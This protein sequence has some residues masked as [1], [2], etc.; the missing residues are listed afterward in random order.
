M[1]AVN[2]A[3]AGEWQQAAPL[4]DP[5]WHHAAG[6]SPDG[7]VFAFG[8]RL[9]LGSKRKYDHGNRENAIDV[10]DPKEKTW[11]RGP[12]IVP[13]R[14]RVVRHYARK[15]VVPGTRNLKSIPAEKASVVS[16]DR[17]QF[18]LP[19]GGSD[20]LGRAHYFTP[21]G[22]VYYDPTTGEWDQSL[23]PIVHS[24]S[25]WNERWLEGGTAPAWNRSAGA[26]ATAPDG[27]MYLVGGQGK[28]K[29]GE[30]KQK[31]RVLGTVEIYDPS[32]EQW[33][34]GSPMNVARQQF[35]AAFGPDGK[36]YVFG[37]CACRGSTTYTVGDKASQER[38]RVEGEAMEH[39]VTRTEVYDPTKDTWSDR[40]AIPTP[41]MSLSAA[42]GLD[43]KI[44]VI[45]GQQRW[46]GEPMSLVEVYDPASDSWSKGPS[47]RIGRQ[48]HASAVTL[49]GK[50]W[51]IGGAGADREIGD[52][53]RLV[54][55]EVGGPQKTVETLQTAPAKK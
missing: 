39:P 24:K 13:L 22:S 43:G 52:I 36:L 1:L 45:G 30:G 53:G 4:P 2:A 40:A 29:Y 42:T 6:A 3:R 34:E 41:R 11:T 23:G 33:S 54:R 10:Y 44:Y 18:E 31:S 9:L 46:G 32:T 27:K 35:G 26:T 20:R 7:H 14:R 15:V 12:E 16:S 38:A 51:V 8:G 21:S 19:F 28:R 37:G 49:D 47:L 55:G 17:F 50:I 48:G 25:K 5:R